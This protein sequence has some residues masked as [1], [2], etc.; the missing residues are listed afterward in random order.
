M[1]EHEALSRMISPG[2]RREGKPNHGV[3]QIHVT[4]ACDLSCYHCTQG[5]NLAGKVSFMTPEQFE[6]ACLSLK[7]YFGTVGVFGGNPCLS[8]HFE[9]YCQILRQHFPQSQC[10]LWSNNLNGH[11]KDCRRTFNPGYS[12]LNVHLSLSAYEE[13]KRDWPESRPFG[14]SEDSRHSPCY[15]AMKDVIPDEGKRWELISNCD[16]NK[17]WSALIGVFRGE[18]RAWFCE[19]AG[20]Q[21]MLH[22]HEKDYPD[23]GLDPALDYDQMGNPVRPINIIRHANGD[24]LSRQELGLGRI[25]KWWELSMLSFRHQVRKHCHEC[26][27]PL[28]GYGE[29]A[30]SEDSDSKEQVSQTHLN[31]YRPKRKDRKVELVVL[32]E[33]LGKPLQNTTKY[34]QNSHL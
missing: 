3:I 4:R 2:M 11:G 33:Q 25:L 1:T 24:P 15:V 30:Q 17:H 18:V 21:A 7:G 27:V 26:S 10:G 23:T 32:Q 9:A 12:N 28:R 29:R 16:I 19:I 5:S 34:L 6:L 13:M 20:A 22:Q 31:I 14:L 8:P